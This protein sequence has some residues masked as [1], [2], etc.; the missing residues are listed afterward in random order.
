[1]SDE[2]IIAD[3]IPQADIDAHDNRFMM[4]LNA[5]GKDFMRN[6][7]WAAGG[8]ARPGGVLR[9]IKVLPGFGRGRGF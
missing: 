2:P 6:L 9:K 3:G 5:F 7:P 8:N 4:D 1:M